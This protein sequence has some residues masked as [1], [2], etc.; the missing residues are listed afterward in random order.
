MMNFILLIF[1]LVLF[2]CVI[3]FTWTLIGLIRSR[4]PYVPTSKNIARAMIELA[5]LKSGQM[6]YDLGCG[7]GKILFMAEKKLR[8]YSNKQ[9]HS[10]FIGY[11]LIRAVVWLGRLKA[12]LR[13]SSVELRC[14]DFFQV[15]LR[16]ADVIFCYLFAEVMDQ[17]Y[18]KKWSELKPGAKLI[19]HAFPIAGLK[20]E[21]V[22]KVGKTKVY[23]YV[24]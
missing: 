12:W 24:K 13:N 4:V 7:D 17:I 9:P 21:K 16:D 19:S 23:V 22:V 2:G 6:I 10:H 5:D 15:D 11:E 14:A 3:F 1:A 8:V 20:P 18:E